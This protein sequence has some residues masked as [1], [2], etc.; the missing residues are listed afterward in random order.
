M[1]TSKSPDRNKKLIFL[2]RKVLDRLQNCNTTTG[3]TIAKDI[4]NELPTS[5]SD[6]DFK[7]IQRR[8]YD[9]LNVL[10]ALDIV[11]K[12]RN[13]IRFQGGVTYNDL[14]ELSAKIA[15]RRE[16]VTY[17]KAR[18]SETL[19][20][21]N[22]LRQLVL[23]N[24]QTKESSQRVYFPL[25]LVKLQSGFCINLIPETAAVKSDLPAE[26]INDTHILGL[27]GLH[28]ASKDFADS[29]P[30]SLLECLSSKSE[31]DFVEL[32]SECSD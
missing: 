2:S 12:V 27:L 32:K 30:E 4:I 15:L 10:H 20:H 17:K 7:N 16:V 23:R 21:M 29:L 28:K 6:V 31:G 14:K 5:L 26:L 1:D 22:A 18:L 19:L 11:S 8:V 24:M 3:N 25:I 9:A 13:E